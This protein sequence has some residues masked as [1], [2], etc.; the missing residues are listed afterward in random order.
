MVNFNY[1]YKTY[2][3]YIRSIVRNII[4]N[5]PDDIVQMAFY[6]LSQ[7]EIN[8][9]QH[10]KALLITT[11]KNMS[12]DFLRKQKRERMNINKMVNDLSMREEPFT[13]QEQSVADLAQI[14]TDVIDFIY[15]EIKRLPNAQRTVF[16]LYLRGMK[17][18]DI[19]A[20]LNLSGQTVRNYLQIA[21]EK[22][23]IEIL[24]N[25]KD[26]LQLLTKRPTL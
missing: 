17:P 21:R 3:N 16:E 6:K 26:A 18:I 12:I 10:A 9:E 15:Q 2:Y 1:I 19:A 7:V 20:H 25:K 22:L 23:K 5:D 14:H 8:D 24:F 4:N 11:A 13:E